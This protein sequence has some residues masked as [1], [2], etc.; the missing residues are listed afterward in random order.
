M[1]NIET[2]LTI[3]N[4]DQRLTQ[5]SERLQEAVKVCYEAESAPIDSNEGYPYAVGWSRSAMNAAVDNLTRIV[6]EY[7]SITLSN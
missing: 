2:Q 5:I 4:M 1:N 3:M 6:K 7:Q